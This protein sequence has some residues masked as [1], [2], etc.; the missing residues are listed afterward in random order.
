MHQ[1]FVTAASPKPLS[2]AGIAWQMCCDF[3]LHCLHNAEEMQVFDRHRQ[4]WQCS[5]ITD[6]EGELSWFC[7]LSVPTV[8]WL[9]SGTADANAKSTTLP[10][11]GEGEV[12]TND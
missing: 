11:A 7:Q 4:P 6:C 3:T 8:W 1:A 2:R 10:W 12:V 5:I 9:L